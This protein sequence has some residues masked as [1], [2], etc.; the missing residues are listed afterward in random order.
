MFDSCRIGHLNYTQ[1]WKLAVRYWY[2]RKN[3]YQ[4]RLQKLLVSASEKRVPVSWRRVYHATKF[5]GVCY[6]H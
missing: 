6:L 1:N 2:S 4:N 5:K 3:E